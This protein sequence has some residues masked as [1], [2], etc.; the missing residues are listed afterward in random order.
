MCSGPRPAVAWAMRIT[1]AWPSVPGAVKPTL[2]APSLFV[3][4]PLIT[5]SI[6]SPSRRAS[7]SRFS[8]TTPTPLPLTVPLASASKARQ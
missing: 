3:A 8:S 7:A 6:W 2:R 5:A 4:D 1:R